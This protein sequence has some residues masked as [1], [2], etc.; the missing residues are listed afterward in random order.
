MGIK[1]DWE[2]KWQKEWDITI[3]ATGWDLT[4]NDDLKLEGI[5]NSAGTALLSV[6]IYRIRFG[7]SETWAVGCEH[8]TNGTERIEGT[9]EPEHGGHSFV[10]TLETGGDGT[11]QLKCVPS[12]ASRIQS[13]EGSSFQ[14]MNQWLGRYI[15]RPIAVGLTRAAVK[16]TKLANYLLQERDT[17][18]PTG[19]WTAEEGG[20]TPIP[21]AYEARPH[22]RQR[23][24]A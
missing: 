13:S 6:T 15:V 9:S 16:A 7:S 17:D 4:T 19:G 8:K 22:V 24:R 12:E 5:W 23:R 11:P 2:A 3:C 14:S 21:L 10:I 1:E 18:E 20:T